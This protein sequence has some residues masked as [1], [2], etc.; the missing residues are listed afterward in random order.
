MA[1]FSSILY[2]CSSVHGFIFSLLSQQSRQSVLLC[3]SK[4]TVQECFQTNHDR[5]FV[6]KVIS[7]SWP[8]TFTFWKKLD[9][10]YLLWG[11]YISEFLSTYVLY[12]NIVPS[13]STA[14]VT[15]YIIW[16]K[17]TRHVKNL[18]K[19]KVLRFWFYSHETLW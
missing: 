11:E 17:K 8:H 1:S 16:V 19:S 7:I 10:S 5:R 13:L 6:A 3:G 4:L 12:S 2:Q 15:K 14:K 18:A 9:T